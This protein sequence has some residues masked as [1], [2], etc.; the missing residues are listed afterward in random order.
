MSKAFEAACK[1]LD[2]TGQPELVLEVIAGRIIAAARGGERD[3]LR[4]REAALLGLGEQD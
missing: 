2:D 4:L 1:Q 3:P